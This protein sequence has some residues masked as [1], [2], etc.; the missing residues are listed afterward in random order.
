MAKIYKKAEEVIAW[1]GESGDNSDEAMNLLRRWGLAFTEEGVRSRMDVDTLLFTM[2]NPKK[3]K[4][5]L[6]NIEDPFS[7]RAWLAL[8]VL[9]KRVYW[10]RL[11]IV[12]EFVLAKKVTLVCGTPSANGNDLLMEHLLSRWRDRASIVDLTGDADYENIWDTVKDDGSYMGTGPPY[13]QLGDKVC[14]IQ[15]ANVPFLL[16][17]NPDKNKGGY[18]LAGE[19]FVLGL[20]DGEFK[21]DFEE[22]T[23]H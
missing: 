13:A 19:A 8:G 21:G 17:P 15:G 14:I 20:M 5:F 23:I 2:Q 22:I 9:F 4:G 11:W 6:S 3:L 10:S 18:L 16:R 1:L 7:H 12:Q